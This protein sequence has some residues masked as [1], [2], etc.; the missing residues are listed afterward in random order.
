MAKTDGA[1]FASLSW[2]SFILLFPFLL[3]SCSYVNGF[4]NLRVGKRQADLS[5]SR[6]GHLIGDYRNHFLF[7]F[8][9]RNQLRNAV[10]RGG[11]SSL[12]PRSARISASCPHL[13][14]LKF[15]NKIYNSAPPYKSNF[16]FFLYKKSLQ[17]PG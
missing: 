13:W 12:F 8:L 9:V 1:G 10:G 14:I 4:D 15:E 2:N 3:E 16:A 5:R 17:I 11:I 6:S 7:S